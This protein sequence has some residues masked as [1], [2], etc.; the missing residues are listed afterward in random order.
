MTETDEPLTEYSTDDNY[1]GTNDIESNYSE[2]I[3]PS[4]IAWGG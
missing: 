1:Y 3:L 4:N 2:I